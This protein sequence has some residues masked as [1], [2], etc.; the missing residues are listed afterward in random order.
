MT[1]V[2]HPARV[3]DFA[4]PMTDPLTTIDPPHSD[5]VPPDDAT[6]S[7]VRGML[8]S[9]AF[10]C[11]LFLSVIGYAAATLSVRA[12]ENHRL[13]E[14]Y[15]AG[16]SDVRQLSEQ[17]Q[18][19]QQYV[20]HLERRGGDGDS[21]DVASQSIAVDSALQFQLDDS[22][23]Q[24]DA[25]VGI[26]PLVEPV[27]W[28]SES[29]VARS[30]LIVGS[31]MLLLFAFVIFVESRRPRSLNQPRHPNSQGPFVRRLRKFGHRYRRPVDTVAE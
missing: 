5:V 17:V 6:G 4:W 7:V 15:A 19:Y 1:W 8:I 31:T 9:L 24:S 21:T 13:F 25:A 14:R 22:T 28:L 23:S 18:R 30:G 29:P 26:R 20:M 11:C 16:E 12:A 3:H 10:W 2:V 27:R